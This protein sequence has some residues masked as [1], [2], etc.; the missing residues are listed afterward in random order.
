MPLHF[1]WLTSDEIQFLRDWVS[2]G[3]KNN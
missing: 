1:E 2:E 3:A